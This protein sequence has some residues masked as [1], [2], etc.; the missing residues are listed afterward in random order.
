MRIRA[1]GRCRG[2]MAIWVIP[3]IRLAT[4]SRDLPRDSG[5]LR[6]DE[7]SSDPP[8]TGKWSPRTNLLLILTTSGLLW[9]AI[10]AAISYVR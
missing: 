1:A 6:T 5:I 2:I 7:Q 9:A 4:T 3:S 8:I 10:F